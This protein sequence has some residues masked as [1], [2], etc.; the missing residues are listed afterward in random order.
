MY[1]QILQIKHFLYCSFQIL[2]NILII[3]ITILNYMYKL[4]FEKKKKNINKK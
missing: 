3:L 4:F 2:M 1:Q